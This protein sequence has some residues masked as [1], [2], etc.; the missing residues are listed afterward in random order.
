MTT[1]SGGKRRNGVGRSTRRTNPG[2]PTNFCGASSGIM[3][4]ALLLI[5]LIYGTE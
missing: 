3:F 4:K 1:E 5:R 2:V